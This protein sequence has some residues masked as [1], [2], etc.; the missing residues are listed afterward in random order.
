VSRET[1]GVSQRHDVGIRMKV[2][3]HD[4]GQC[5]LCN[6]NVDVLMVG[7]LAVRSRSGRNTV[8][9]M[10]VLARGVRLCAV[11]SWIVM[12]LAEWVL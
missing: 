5:P 4:A 10:G 7:E 12:D 9:C 6:V 8:N 2:Q 11:I 1:P 3:A